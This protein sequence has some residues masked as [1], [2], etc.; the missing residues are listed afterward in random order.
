V[1]MCV[2][3]DALTTSSPDPTG[4]CGPYTPLPPA[5]LQPEPLARHILHSQAAQR[6]QLAHGSIS[7]ADVVERPSSHDTISMVAIDT[8]G[9]C[10]AD[11]NPVS[12]TTQFVYPCSFFLSCC[13]LSLC[14]SASLF[15]YLY[16]PM[17]PPLSLSLSLSLSLYLSLFFSSFLFLSLVFTLCV[18]PLSLSISVSLMSCSLTGNIAAGVSTNGLTHK[19]AGRVGDAPIP[20]AGAYAEQGS[21]SLSCRWKHV[22]FTVEKNDGFARRT[23]II[24]PPGVLLGS[25]RIPSCVAC[26][27]AMLTR[28]H[29]KVSNKHLTTFNFRFTPTSPTSHE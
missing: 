17:S 28:F 25:I 24:R 20:G 29:T 2:R 9:V 10:P 6:H 13:S 16:L 3:V 8:Q 14:L 18:T 11:L 5:L 19:V 26:L 4:S 21:T 23:P 27:L 7:A 1:Y 22:Y 12:E 15:L